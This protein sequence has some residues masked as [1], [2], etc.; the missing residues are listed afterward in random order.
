MFVFVTI[1]PLFL[2]DI[3]SVTELREIQSDLRTSKVNAPSREVMSETWVPLYDKSVRGDS[4]SLEDE[5]SFSPWSGKL[6][7]A[8]Y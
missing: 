2:K 1:T 7:V 5:E 6:S 4:S 3:T 8:V